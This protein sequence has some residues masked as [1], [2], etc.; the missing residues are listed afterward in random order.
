MYATMSSIV[1][2]FRER[3]AFSQ[4]CISRAKGCSERVP[5]LGGRTKPGAPIRRI[6]GGNSNKIRQKALERPS[7]AKIMAVLIAA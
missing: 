2:P 5:L 3:A 1:D 4:T 6:A 7:R